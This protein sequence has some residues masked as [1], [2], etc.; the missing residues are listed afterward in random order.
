MFSR[1]YGTF[2][3]GIDL[4]DDKAA[5]LAKPIGVWTDIP[6]L[7]VPL[8]PSGRSSARPLVAAG[9]RVSSGDKI[10]EAADLRG[11]DVFA[12]VS[13][14]VAGI[15]QTQVRL[16]WSFAQVDAIE[17]TDLDTST[18]A[19]ADLAGETFH[20][21]QADGETVRDRL[22]GG[23]VTAYN[24]AGASIAAW[25]DSARRNRCR[26]LIANAMES[27]PYVTSAHRMLVEY[28]A[29]VIWGLAILAKAIEADEVFLAVDRRRTDDYLNLAAPGDDH[30]VN[31]IALPH[32]YPTGDDIMLTKI[33]TRR[34]VPPGGGVMDVGSAVT[35]VATCL[36]VHRWVGCG[37][38]ATHRVVT[39][40]GERAPKRGDFWTPF[41]ANCLSLTGDA[42]APIFHGGPMTGARCTPE[43]VVTAGTD[44]VLAIDSP[45]PAPPTPCIRCG[46]CTDHCPARLN[47]AV[48]N[49]FAELSHVRLAERIG[50]MACVQCGVC[51]YVCPAR[52]P[53][54]QRLA[55]LKRAIAA[56]AKADARQE[57]GQ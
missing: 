9:D 26:T 52:L 29:Q 28:G 21:R 27:Q 54:A 2:T 16:R 48:L 34:E 50:A 37:R 46:W 53:L 43:T 24:T 25:V 49:D 38:P 7:C 20:W 14:Q 30:D 57:V 17:L 40:S 22:R 42:E 8:S 31:H 10:A 56:G 55:Q 19:A 1:R 33:L 44:A 18:S 51:S 12:P 13:G 36:A 23:G 6:R 4:P 47:V 41:G 11:V 35:D 5:T 45:K 39:V 3:G 15:V 32:K